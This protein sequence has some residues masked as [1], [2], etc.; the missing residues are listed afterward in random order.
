MLGSKLKK[1]F[2]WLQKKT[3]SFGSLALVGG[4]YRSVDFY[5]TITSLPFPSQLQKNIY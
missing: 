1:N 5:Y 2:V 3:I 4:I